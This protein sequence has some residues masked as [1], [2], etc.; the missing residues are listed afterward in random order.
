[1]FLKR[2]ERQ[3]DYSKEKK[4]LYRNNYACQN[5][6]NQET[7]LSQFFIEELIT[8]NLNENGNKLYFV[9]NITIA[10]LWMKIWF[11]KK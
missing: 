11:S 1:M 5:I 2:T 8:S 9:K 6:L 7:I 4:V 10:Y 3:T